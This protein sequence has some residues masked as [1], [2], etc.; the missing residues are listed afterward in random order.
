MSIDDLDCDAL[1]SRL[2]G[3][4]SPP[5]RIAF[6]RAAEETLA[7]VPCWG[8]FYGAVAALQRRFFELPYLQVNYDLDRRTRLRGMLSQNQGA[9][10]K[11]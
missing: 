4:L 6:R 8:A 2:A 1:I 9:V 5:D 3:P 10:P 11:R 7:R